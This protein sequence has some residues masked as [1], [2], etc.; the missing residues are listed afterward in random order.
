[1][2]LY[3]VPRRRH[4][5]SASLLALSL[6]LG[7][8]GCGGDDSSTAP[9]PA[10]TP[11]PA[12][13]IAFTSAGTAIVPENSAGAIYTAAATHS[14][15]SAVIFAI[16]GGNDAADF[17]IQPTGQLSFA[18]APDFERPADAD[19]DNVYLVTLQ[20]S[21]GALSARLDVAI[22]VFNDKEGIAVR[23]IAT[24][25][26]DPVC[27]DTLLRDP[28]TGSD[29]TGQIAVG[30]RGGKIYRIDGGSGARAQIADVFEGRT[31]AEL[32]EC[33]SHRAQPFYSGLFGVV[34]EANG[35]TAMDRY[36]RGRFGD[37]VMLL[38]PGAPSVPIKLISASASAL[39]AAIGDPT[40]S[41]AQSA[42]SPLGKL[43]QLIER[44]PYAGASLRVPPFDARLA[45]IGLREPGGGS[46]AGSFIVL[47]DRGGSREHELNV[48]TP[49]ST[50]LDFGWPFREGSATLS[51]AGSATLY[52]PAVTYLFGRERRQG[53]GIVAGRPYA[54]PATALRDRYVFADRNGLIWSIPLRTL[55]DGSASPAGVLENRTA[56]FAP[57]A[58]S[59][60]SPVGF[61]TDGSGRFYI[62]DSDGEVFRVEGS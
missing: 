22:T 18:Q 3:R 46:G 19:Q 61:A 54:G 45:G 15:G 4:V 32:I 34:R 39:Y 62:L 52:N 55:Q 50:V 8:S 42:A 14:G 57:D 26:T 28:T 53:L 16:T 38:P 31:A 12:A 9:A 17:T 40:G 35:F 29:V 37:S 27:I 11:A 59:I 5:A 24:G 7:L 49:S 47:S 60:D 25:L 20:A 33:V 56:D 6:L 23:R 58:G 13:T 43:F 44:D 51:D 48:F 1:M 2:N 41:S 10:P 36:D 30:E 21:S